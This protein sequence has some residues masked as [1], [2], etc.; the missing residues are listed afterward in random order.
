MEFSWIYQSESPMMVKHFLKEQ[1]VSRGLL[2]K[3]KFQ[4]GTI[5][6]NQSEQNALFE[7]K[8]KDQ[9]TLVIPSEGEHETVLQDTTAIEIVYE[10]EHV[11]IVNKPSGVA[12][13]PAQYHP[14]GT[15]ANRVKA[16][17]CQQGYVDRVIHVV[18][19]LDRDTSGLMLFAKHGYAHALLDQQ[20]RQKKLIKKYQALVTGGKENLAQHACI[21]LPIGRDLTSLIKRKVDQ[22]GKMAETE[23]WTERQTAD[24]SLVDIQLHTGRTH[25]IRVHFEAIG[26]PLLGDTLY[27]G[28]LNLG[29]KRQALHCGS[30][31]FMHPFTKQ[32]LDFYLEIPADMRQ[33]MQQKASS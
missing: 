26:C 6:V 17:Y 15:M 24:W 16:Y 30:L 13:I 31:R 11:L 19:R 14:N 5:L 32:C 8:K 18:T 23:Y 10:D 21:K 9:I 29:I 1:G 7:L 3:V 27:G 2:A 4:G 25:Q 28:A 33:V 12:S 20:L 22:G